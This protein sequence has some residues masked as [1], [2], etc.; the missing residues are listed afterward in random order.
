MPRKHTPLNVTVDRTGTVYELK[1]LPRELKDVTVEVAVS[2]VSGVIGTYA[3]KGWV[4]DGQ[5]RYVQPDDINAQLK[6]SAQSTRK[7]IT[8]AVERRRNASNGLDGS[9][10]PAE[11]NSPAEGHIEAEESK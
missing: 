5:L 9:L 7:I 1:D 2:G 4:A 6:E 11:G 10:D 3:A 8:E